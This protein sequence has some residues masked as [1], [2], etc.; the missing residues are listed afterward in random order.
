MAIF[1]G[2]V[3]YPCEFAI[4][5]LKILDFVCHVVILWLSL[6]RVDDVM[7]GEVLRVSLDF[8]PDVAQILAG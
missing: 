4:I 8:L 6:E 5:P 7:E 3:V 2:I 1:F